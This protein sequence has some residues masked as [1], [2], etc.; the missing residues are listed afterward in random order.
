MAFQDDFS[1]CMSQNGINIDPSAVPADGATLTSVLDYIKQYLQGL[2]PDIAAGLDDVCTNNPTNC[3]L[4]DL[5]IVDSSYQPL[6]QAFDAATGFSLT[7][8]IQWSEYC[9][10][11]ANQAAGQTT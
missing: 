5:N 6:L 1:Q 11:V 8:C 4:I 3:A 2:D 10:G 9:T 7:L